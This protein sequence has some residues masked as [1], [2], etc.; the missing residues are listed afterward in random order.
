MSDSSLLRPRTEHGGAK[1]THIE[2]FFD[3]IFVFA[4]TQLSH[5]LLEDLSAI[6]AVH[7][8]LLLTAVW[9]AWIYT[10][11]VT[12]WLDP[13]RTPVRVM[14][15]LV[16]LAGLLLAASLPHAFDHEA[17]LFAITY[18]V[19]QVGRSLFALW[20]VGNRR[21][22]LTGTFQ[23]I[24]M[25]FAMSGALWLAGAA[26][27]EWRLALWALALAIEC[28]GPWAGYFVPGLGH[29]T[30]SD[31]NVDGEHLAERC[32]LFIIIALGES[33]LVTGATAASVTATFEVDAA[34][35]VAFL[36]TVAMWWI[37]FNVGVHRGAHEIA[38]A[39]EPGRLARHAYTYVH[40]VI[41]AGIIVSAVADEI[42]LVHPSG[43]VEVSAVL[44]IVGGPTLFLLGNLWF[45]AVIWGRMPLSHL[46]GFVLLALSAAAASIMTPLMLAAAVST[47]LLVVAGW[48]TISLQPAGRGQT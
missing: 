22:E 27:E 35:V 20:A 42:I 25:W 10:A 14:L 1:V 7:T 2:L 32:A 46:A 30:V 33:I 29:S 28:A 19:I 47:I 17:P 43:H 48:E 34:F 15:F 37:Y 24:A 39:R 13:D 8:A 5:A 40:L 38:A 45:K 16:M 4:I 44:A 6:G 3:L 11:W 36:S 23:R 21:P 12:N 18:V 41:V 9:W 26:L 31:W